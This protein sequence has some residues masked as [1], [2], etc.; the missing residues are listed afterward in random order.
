[1]ATWILLRHGQSVA[2]AARRLAGVRIR[3]GE[4]LL[5]YAMRVP[6]ALNDGLPDDD[7]DCSR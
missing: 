6:S 1:M 3:H 7:D 5:L 2:N 4:L